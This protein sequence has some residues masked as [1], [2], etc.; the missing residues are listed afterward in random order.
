M[1][2]GFSFNQILFEQQNLLFIDYK[3]P[4]ALFKQASKNFILD[5][6]VLTEQDKMWPYYVVQCCWKFYAEYV[7][8]FMIR[9][10]FLLCLYW[11]RL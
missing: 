11:N 8:N 9:Y 4:M 2:V 7:M 3:N 5:R 6:N 1:I 10:M